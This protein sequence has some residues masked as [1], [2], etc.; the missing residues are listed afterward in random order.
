MHAYGT[1]SKAS[2]DWQKGTFVQQI[3]QSLF[4]A[5]TG[6]Y[7]VGRSVVLDHKIACDFILFVVS[8]THKK[9]NVLKVPLFNGLKSLLVP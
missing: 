3:L 8:F 2:A 7:L 1:S 5:S 9:C 4:A 6:I